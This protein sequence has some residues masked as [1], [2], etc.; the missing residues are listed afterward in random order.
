LD[1]QGFEKL[2]SDLGGPV[3]TPGDPRYDSFRRLWNGRIEK[4]PA[5]IARCTSTAD[6]AACVRFAREY[7]LNLAVRGSGHAVAGTALCNG[8]LVAD[9]SGVKGIQIDPQSRRARV[10]PGETWG[11]L[12]RATQVFGL[13]VP[14]GTD[15]EVGVSGLTLGGGNGWL[16][17]AFGATVDNLLSV[18]LVL[19]D[20]DVIIASSQEHPDLCWAVRGG[21]G[22]FGIATNFEF[23]LHR[24]G[25]E[26]FA[27]AVYYPFANTK[28][29]LQAFREVAEAFPDPLT[30]YPCLIFDHGNNPVLCL[31][32]CYAG[33]VAD[34]ERA[35]APLRRL[36][37]FLHDDL[38]PRPFVAWQ[39]AM[40][41]ARPAGRG[42]AIRS[43]FL[44]RIDDGFVDA[45]TDQFARSPSLLSVVVLEHCHG[46]I[47]RVPAQATAFALR[48]NPYHFEILAFWNGPAETEVNLRWAD[49]FLAAT[50]PFSAGEV[51]V[52]SLDEAEAD[53]VPEAYGVNFERLR[54]V[55]KKYDPQN[56]FHCNQNIPPAC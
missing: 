16:M 39:A 12:D 26:V 40:D 23:A 2:R 43:H 56:F 5:G 49:D 6:I 19:A 55:K 18:E 10:R 14:G 51:Y 30:V 15:S 22:N 7:D 34:G 33:P 52:N 38:A 32:A 48:G 24:V 29:V 13:A 11:S 28:R 37:R 41:A 42:C 4:Y 27:G 3:L 36:G 21:G 54:L 20:G 1:N 9:L 47:A 50:L 8:G 44:P 35:A 46:A 17:G 53:R 45:L 31:A 25:P